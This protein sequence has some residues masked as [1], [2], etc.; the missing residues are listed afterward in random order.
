MPISIPSS[1]LDKFTN[2]GDLLRFLRRRVSLTQMELANTVGYSHTQIS[3][4]EQNLRLPDIPTIESNFVYALGLEDEPKVVAH[5]LELATN[6]R[7]EDA[8]T[9]G[10]CP[11]KGLNFYDETD[12]DLF[13]G[14]ET[15]TARLTERLFSLTVAGEA[16]RKRFLAV[17]G[18]SG[19]GKSSLVRAGLISALRW[20]KTSSDWASHVCTPTE[21]PLESL[22]KE[23]TQE[24]DS[25]AANLARQLMQ[26][27]QGLKDFASKGLGLKEKTYLLLI[28]DQFEELFTICRSEEEQVAFIDNLL[29]AASDTDSPVIVVIT[30]RADFY[31]YC[32]NFPLLR[33]ALASNQE[34]IGAMNGKELRRVIEEP[35]QRGR[36]ELEPGLVD[37]LLHDVGNEPGAL[38][39]LSHALLETWQRRRGRTM[40]L[41]SYAASGGVRG[42]IAE[43][44]ESV[45]TDQ[46]TREQ[47]SI[48]R[49]IFLRL[50]ELNDEA[51]AANTRRRATLDE[52]ILIPEEAGITHI[53]LNALADA[54]LI[55][56]DQNTAEV[57]HEALIREWPTLRNWLEENRDGLRLHRQLTETAQDWHEM[58]RSADMLFRGSRLTQVQEWAL[59]HA[60]EM[61]VLEREFLT[62]SQE[63]AE[64]EAAKREAQR[65]RELEATQKLAETEHVRAEEQA[66]SANRLRSR[67]RV[68]TAIGSIA[69]I[70]AIIAGIFGSQASQNA[71]LAYNNAAT[72]QA[73]F[74]RSE[75]QRLALEA[76]NLI[77]NNDDPNLAALLAIRS[78]T[79]QYTPSGD[80]VLTSLTTLPAPPRLLTGHL[81]DTF[82]IAL[83][84]DDRYVVAG[85]ADQTA[86]LWDLETGQT[87]RVFYG[88][89]DLVAGVD[90]SPDGKYIVTGS[91]DNTARLWDVSTGKTVQVFT[92]QNDI[93]DNI[94]FSP[95]GRFI[96]TTGPGEA[97]VWNISTG[98]TVQVISGADYF[99]VRYSPDGKY[100][101]IGS[102]SDA[103]IR[104]YDAQTFEEF[105]VFENP[106]TAGCI[107]F[108]PDGKTIAAAVDHTAIRIWDIETG[109][110][111]REFSVNNNEDFND[112]RFSPD[113]QYLIT[114]A[115]VG[116]T[117]TIFE[118]AT[119]KSYRTFKS[120]TAIQAA[121][122]THDGRS[123]LITNRDKVEIW[124][125]STSPG[126]MIFSVNDQPIRKASFSP[127]GT[128]VAT[129]SNDH[130]ARI[131]DVANG[132]TLLILNRHT[133][134][135]TDAVFS[136]DG[137]MI[138]TGSADKTARLWDA[139]TGEELRRFEGH[140]DEVEKVLFSPD[141]KY[142]VTASYDGTARVWE[143]QTGKLITIYTNQNSGQLIRTAFSP[144]GKTVATT[145]EDRTTR[146]WDPITGKELMVFRGHTDIVTGVAFSPDGKLLLTSSWD[147]TSRLWDV[148]SG[149]ELR[150]FIGHTGTVFGAAF[151]P[152]GKYILTSGADQ[153]ARLWDIQTGQELRR[154]AGHTDEI[155]FATFSPNGKYILTA[156]QDGTARLWLA[157][158]Q[159]TIHAICA[160][161]TRDFESEERTKFGIV[162]SGPTCPA[163]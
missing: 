74:T 39:L 136:P 144:D 6:V 29:V 47:Q 1:T 114:A 137:K 13:V 36:W 158:L 41:S 8:P 48:A 79:L 110:M 73:D 151:S 67:N 147:G 42:A 34:Y 113:G 116:Q 143:I 160:A 145:G 132:K 103:L 71:T 130:T 23:L 64:H 20:N 149:K 11:Y 123:V 66:Q 54:R 138:L 30:L 152:D 15:L 92:G 99:R 33:E 35:A 101:A 131:W 46:F 31:A 51:S 82:D 40:T 162:G 133:A 26:S 156:S 146:I 119:G 124:S 122:F 37:L 121:L 154:F 104:L 140:M 106:D 142:I 72:A 18:A 94:I 127:E 90:F 5:L 61:N 21:H 134:E 102:L 109:Q 68:I 63:W 10:L 2:F 14:R 85:G 163:Q 70:L 126:G 76:N 139:S 12:A 45:F 53:V 84:P 117:A 57:A 161:L 9:P 105:R 125:L 56:T 75:A 17:V 153:T 50:T 88:H 62:A 89:N 28:V 3:R 32:A 129:A 24:N 77:I 159:D 157:D 43:T 93:V 7:R 78:L 86:R 108:S 112:L 22:A 87:V 55:V 98:Q 60:D 44:A 59:T 128:Q 38:P 118:V 97:R 80:A 19:S 135:V 155:R 148:T 120:A 141:G 115:D 58:N 107:A 100:F 95:D 65:Q 111:V 27:S 150:V 96:I 49:K 91:H 4:L 69:V 25:S 52:L 16:S 81:G 83:S